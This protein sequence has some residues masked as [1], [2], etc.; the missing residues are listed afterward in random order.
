M[1]EDQ[2]LFISFSNCRGQMHGKTI[3]LHH[4]SLFMWC[5]SLPH[6]ITI[7]KAV[8]ADKRILRW[9]HSLR[10]IGVHSPKKLVG[11][12]THVAITSQKNGRLTLTSVSRS[13]RLRWVHLSSHVWYLFSCMH[14]LS[15]C[16]WHLFSCMQ[17]I[18][19]TLGQGTLTHANVA[20]GLCDVRSR[21]FS[22]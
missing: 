19:H 4:S 22:L 12:L 17:H 9:A 7:L 10:I 1:L 14:H 5:L 3:S 13:L 16:M 18:L 15:S 21:C 2:F 20:I 8:H 6:S 11:S